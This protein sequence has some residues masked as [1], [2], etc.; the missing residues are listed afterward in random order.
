MFW[1]DTAVTSACKKGKRTGEDLDLGH[2]D[3]PVKQGPVASA[4][5]APSVS[6]QLLGHSRCLLCFERLCPPKFVMW[7]SYPPR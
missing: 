6:A 2:E 3:V 7:E 1:R 4:T 5:A